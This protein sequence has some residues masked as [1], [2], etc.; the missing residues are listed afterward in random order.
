MGE[1][2][3]FYDGNIPYDLM[4]MICVLHYGDRRSDY[5]PFS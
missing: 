1:R 3:C 2:C 5:T 4:N